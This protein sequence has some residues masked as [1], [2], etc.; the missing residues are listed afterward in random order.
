LTDKALNGEYRGKVK[1]KDCRSNQ[2]SRV[3]RCPKCGSQRLYK[4][5]V[6]VLA[7][8]GETQRYLCR[9]CGYR[10]SKRQSL[11]YREPM[12]INGEFALRRSGLLAKNLPKAVMGLNEALEKS[13]NGLAGA[14]KQTIDIKA[15]SLSFHGG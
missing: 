8:G 7:D 13:V 6:R 9:R 10:F 15:K 2:D 4:D 5:G 11:Y 12:N 1:A 14:T 3:R